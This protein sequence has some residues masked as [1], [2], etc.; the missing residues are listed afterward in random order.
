MKFNRGDTLIHRTDSQRG[1]AHAVIIILLVV[2]LSGTLGYVF[3]QNFVAKK[4]ETP[5]PI[6]TVESTTKTTQ[7]AFNSTIYEAEH[8]KN[9][10]VT[11]TEADKA[12]PNDVMFKLMNPEKSVLMTVHLFETTPDTACNQADGL[13]VSYYNVAT[14][15][16]TDFTAAPLYF[17]ETI[18]DHAGGGYDYKIG[19]TEEGGDTHSALGESHC[20][21]AR[22]GIASTALVAVDTKALVRPSITA[23]ITFPK[24]LKESETA[25]KEMQPIKAMFE[26]DGYKTAVKVIESLRKK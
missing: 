6:Q 17:V 21:V 16:V 5:V 25:V 20:N 23:T 18:N 11:N 2:A 7:V 22:V 10:T 3:Y 9:W 26:T 4:D 19:L 1:S 14:K 13:K 24:L 8:P 15:P 12:K